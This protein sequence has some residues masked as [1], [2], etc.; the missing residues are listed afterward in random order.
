MV[1]MRKPRSVRL[2]LRL[3]KVDGGP[4]TRKPAEWWADGVGVEAGGLTGVMTAKVLNG[5]GTT[6]RSYQ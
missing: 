1:E 5:S 2:L 6:R 4:S 3:S